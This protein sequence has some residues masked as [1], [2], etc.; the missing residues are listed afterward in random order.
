MKKS[1]IALAVMG[2]FAGG[3]AHAADS[4][5]L[6]GVLD[7]GVE[8]VDNGTN[9]QTGLADGMGATSRIGVKG[10]EDLGGG[11]KAIFQAEFGFANGASQNS[12]L[13]G[14]DTYVG[15][16]GGFGTVLAGRISSLTD[17]VVLGYNAFGSANLG[18]INVLGNWG[19]SDKLITNSSNNWNAY[20]PLSRNNTTLAYVSPDFGGFTAGA[21]YVFANG[22][23]T[24]NSN[25]KT[26]AA[27]N[28]MAK[29]ANGPL[30]VAGAYMDANTPEGKDAFKHF[31][32]GGSYDLGVVK[33]F[34][35][36]VQNKMY[37]ANIGATNLGGL[38]GVAPAPLNSA[39][40][41][42]G[43]LA[44]PN[45]TKYTAWSLGASAPIGPG[46]LMVSYGQGK[47]NDISASKAQ[48]FSLGYNYALSKRTA[49]YAVY[50]GIKND[51]NANAM[52]LN[53]GVTPSGASYGKNQNAI[54]LGITHKF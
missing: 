19:V 28:L 54:G 10:A 35:E 7:M 12:G 39:G 31:V 34:G 4:V 13:T 1:L 3:V 43:A 11:L 2:A 33:L 40:F 24:T 51:T 53:Q 14:R 30:S 36:Y 21:A 42:A 26:G 6:Y 29:Y 8:R 5:Q 20:D 22:T 49:L 37:L 41:V 48:Q 44:N 38:T 47:W 25:N 18:G 23:Y 46:S 17:G 9:S 50:Q 16:N 27:Y 15:L 45:G 52:V 32:L